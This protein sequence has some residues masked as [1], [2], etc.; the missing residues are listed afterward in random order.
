VSDKLQDLRTALFAAL[1]EV[2]EG[3][4]DLDRA[5]AINEI[6]K[7][8]IDTAKVEIDYIRATGGVNSEFLESER[9]N[10]KL[11]GVT[12]HLLRG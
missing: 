9:V 12:R 7:T 2:K 4:L 3:H 6:S 11:P 10:G 1:R 8:L 5:R